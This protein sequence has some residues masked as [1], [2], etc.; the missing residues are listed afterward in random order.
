MI[1]RAIMRSKTIQ[2]ISFLFLAFIIQGY[3][4]EEGQDTLHLSLQEA[5]D[6]AMEHNVEVQ[7]AGIDV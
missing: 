1:K 7:N 5:Q 4:Q 2:V 3:A 6:Y